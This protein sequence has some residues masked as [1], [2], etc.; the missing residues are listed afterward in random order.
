MNYIKRHKNGVLIKTIN[1]E[2]II[3][4]DLINYINQLCIQNLSTYQGRKKAAKQLLKSQINH[5][6]YV[7]KKLILYPTKSIRKFDCYYINYCSVLSVIKHD[8]NCTKIIF[9][10]LEELIVNVSPYC[11]KKQHRNIE[12]LLGHIS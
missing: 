8:Y 6:I 10:D 9:T 7:H 4:E 5:P 11:I 12:N 2:E 1:N 3:D